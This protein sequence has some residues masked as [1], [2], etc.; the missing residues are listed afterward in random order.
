M[1]YVNV[2]LLVWGTR[3]IFYID[4]LLINLVKE[5]IL[6]IQNL[7]S[8]IIYSPYILISAHLVGC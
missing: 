4:Q 8:D 7:F 3:N 1:S 5:T 6:L 2:S